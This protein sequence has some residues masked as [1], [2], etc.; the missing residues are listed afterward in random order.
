MRLYIPNKAQGDEESNVDEEEKEGQSVH[1][2][3]NEKEPKYS[4]GILKEEIMKRA[5][6]GSLGEAI[7]VVTEVPMITPRGKFDLHFIKNVLKVHGPSHDY[8][9]SYKNIS[10]AFLLPKPDGVHFAFVVSLTNPLRQGNTS[11]PFLVF[12]FR[13]QTEKSVE[14]NLPED[15]EERN[16]ILKSNIDTSLKGELLDI[17][18]K[19]FKAVVG[20]PVVIPGS[21][22]SS[23][24][25]S[26][27]KCSLKANDGFIYLLERGIIF[28]QKPVVYLAYEDIRQVEF[29]RISESTVQQRT[30][31]LTIKK[32]NE[33]IQ[34]IGL[35][36]N[37]LD[38]LTK[39]FAS[40]KI[41]IKSNDGGNIQEIKPNVYFIFI[42]DFFFNYQKVKRRTRRSCNGIAF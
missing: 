41:I 42:L 16:Q 21:F 8:K 35:E 36:K 3:D 20:V 40:K 25:A 19:L 39:Y 27:V 2:V 15:E 28:I 37:E 13:K 1:S 14:L 26:C 7:A 31:D 30:F 23:K 4:A 29:S 32:K 38:P 24:G 18:A 34:L 6:V 22:R 5:N 12:Q 9:I 17:V 11:Y 33:D 10:K